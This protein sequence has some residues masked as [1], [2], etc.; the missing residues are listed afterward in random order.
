MCSLNKDQRLMLCDIV[1]FCFPFV[2][3]G[4]AILINKKE[5]LRAAVLGLVKFIS[6]VACIVCV[7]LLCLVVL[8]DDIL[9]FG[10]FFFAPLVWLVRFSSLLR[11]FNLA[12]SVHPF[13]SLKP[14]RVKSKGGAR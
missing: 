10:V 13:A 2:G 12:G 1:G 3:L 11:I 5:G 14:Q 8:N 4:L 6:L 7:A 9:A